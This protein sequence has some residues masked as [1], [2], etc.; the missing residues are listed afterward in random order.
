MSIPVVEYSFTLD[1]AVKTNPNVP[2][3]TIPKSDTGTRKLSIT[4]KNSGTAIDLTDL[5]PR[6]YFKK[7][8]GNRTQGDPTVVDAA[9]GQISYT[10]NTND[11]SKEGLVECQITLSDAS[12][13]RITTFKFDLNVLPTAYDDSAVQSTTE[14][15]ILTQ[16]V[17]N[18]KH[19]GEYATGTTYYLNNLVSYSG[20][21]YIALQITTGN[22]PPIYPDRYNDYWYIVANGYTTVIDEAIDQLSRVAWVEKND[23]SFS[24]PHSSAPWGTVTT[25]SDYYGAGTIFKITGVF[26]DGSGGTIDT[27]YGKVTRIIGTT[28]RTLYVY[29][30]KP[31]AS[32][33]FLS[34]LETDTFTQYYVLAGQGMPSEIQ[35]VFDFPG[36]DATDSALYN[37]V[38]YNETTLYMNSTSAQSLYVY[39]YDTQPCPINYRIKIVQ[40]NTAQTT[41]V[42][43]EPGTVTVDS[44][45][46]KFKTAGQWAETYLTQD[47]LNH[48]IFSGQTST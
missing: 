21:T 12:A 2:D 1:Y 6:I 20:A 28:T 11:V 14:F 30:Y 40:K 23:L 33:E 16:Y 46:N 34:P 3:I 39:G 8:D 45:G 10:L 13:G 42:N 22:A 44:Y 24:T 5:T 7:S 43:A 9:T 17:D 26:D 38:Q 41:I 4:L 32:V 25:T 15:S 36:Y 29:F 27:V 37:Y 47:S 18:F 31:G 35:G 19:R 48:W